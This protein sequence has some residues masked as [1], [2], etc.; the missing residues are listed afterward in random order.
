RTYKVAAFDPTLV[1]AQMLRSPWS[2]GDAL[3][4]AGGWKD[5]ATPALKRML[6]DPESLGELH[7]SLGAMDELGR[8]AAYDLRRVST[9]S[10][11]ELIQRR[12]APGLT[13]EETA[14]RVAAE[15]ARQDATRRWNW[16]LSWVFGSLLSLLVLG[17]L[18][19]TWER[20]RLGKKS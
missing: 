9:E 4:V 5:Y 6:L 14:R 10:F 1:F 3:V 11:A 8:G 12:I 16:I 2:Q 15:Q 18:W 19:L 20:T 13:V 7:G 17:R